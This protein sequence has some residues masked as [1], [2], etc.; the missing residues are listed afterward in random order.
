MQN[1]NWNILARVWMSLVQSSGNG[2][3][4][5][6]ATFPI[7]SPDFVKECINPQG[8][9]HENK[10]KR[11]LERNTDLAYFVQKQTYDKVFLT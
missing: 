3:N 4:F 9:T 5:L 1:Q 8:E 11:T 10:Q 7:S 2:C 6:L